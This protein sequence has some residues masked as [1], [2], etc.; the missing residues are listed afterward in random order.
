M[1]A[2]AYAGRDEYTVAIPLKPYF[3][4]TAYESSPHVTGNLKM[5]LWPIRRKVFRSI[6]VVRFPA[7]ML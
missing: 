3:E 5:D 6:G 2:L 1:R 4:G 7:L